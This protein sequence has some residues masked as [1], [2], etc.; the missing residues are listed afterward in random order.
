[1]SWRPRSKYEATLQNVVELSVPCLADWCGVYLVG[2]DESSTR[3]RSRT[4]TRAARGRR[5]PVEAMG[6]ARGVEHGLARVV[7]TRESLLVPEIKDALAESA[8]DDEHL[9]MMRRLGMQSAMVAPLVAGGLSI[10]AIR[11]HPNG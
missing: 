10:G 8:V 11:L 5:R 3:W 4:V 1:M 2:T 7:R 9:A 6:T